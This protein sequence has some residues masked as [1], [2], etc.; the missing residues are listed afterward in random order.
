M[1]LNKTVVKRHKNKI[2]LQGIL[3]DFFQGSPGVVTQI[4][5]SGVT[6]NSSN[7]TAE[8]RTDQDKTHIP[9]KFYNFTLILSA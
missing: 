3:T 5:R 6:A 8:I 9:I 2:Y 7:N 4:S 1:P